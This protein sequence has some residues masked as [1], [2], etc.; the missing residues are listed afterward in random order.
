MRYVLDLT[1]K[2]AA[3]RLKRASIVLQAR[4]RIRRLQAEKQVLAQSLALHGNALSN[5]YMQQNHVCLRAAPP[6]D[7]PMYLSTS[8]S[9]A[10]VSDALGVKHLVAQFGLTLTST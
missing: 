4:L 8:L 10:H 5:P 3:W 1:I 9:L 6:S 7:Q 2:I